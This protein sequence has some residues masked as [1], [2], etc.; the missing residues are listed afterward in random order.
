LR[1]TELFIKRR[2]NAPLEPAVAIECDQNGIATGVRT[3]PFR[4]ALITSQA[5]SAELGF[6]PGDLRENIVM[7][8]D[9]LHELPSGTDIQVGPAL[10][11]LTFHCEPCRKYLS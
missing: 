10:L 6:R 1:V 11:R 4:H 2:H 5:I 9:A 3:A 8:C 7:D